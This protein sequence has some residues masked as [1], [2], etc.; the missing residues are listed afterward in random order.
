MN[1]LEIAKRVNKECGISGDGPSSVV[2]QTG[3]S[4]KVVNWARTAHDEVQGTRSEWGFD[5]AT[6]TQVLVEAQESY[7]MANDWGL[8]VKTVVKHGLY[9]YRTIDGPAAKHWPVFVSWGRFREMRL[10]NATGLPIYWTQ[11]PDNTLYFHPIPDAGITTV[12]EFY[13]NPLELVNNFDV[14]RLPLRHHMAIVWR[15]VMFFCASEENPALL[16]SANMN[17]NAIM[18][19]MSTSDLPEMED[20]EPMA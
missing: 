11:A 8:D 1:F 12:L 15:A 10:P 3:M 6:S 5:W 14:P 17:F 9:L 18:L 20:P 13:R 4:A 19:R 16:Q 7:G 2:S